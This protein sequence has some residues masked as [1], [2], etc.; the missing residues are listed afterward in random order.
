M[1]RHTQGTDF[2]PA[3]EIVVPENS[4]RYLAKHAEGF[5][6]MLTRKVILAS[7]IGASSVCLAQD[8]SSPSAEPRIIIESKIN[9]GDLPYRGLYKMYLRLLSFLPPAPHII[10][11]VTQLSFTSLPIKDEDDF[12]KSSWN[13]AIVGTDTDIDIPILRGGYF[14]FPAYGDK[15][16]K[17]ANLMFNS[18]TKTNFLRVA[19]KMRLRP[20]QALGFP[21]VKQALHEVSE[22]QKNI[23][24][25]SIGFRAEKYAKFDAIK[26]CFAE[27][28]GE[29]RLDGEVLDTIHSA[30]CRVYK[31]DPQ[32]I[33]TSRELKFSPVPEIVVLEDSARYLPRPAGS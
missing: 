15:I 20:H 9:R 2:S 32:L 23:P 6:I 17:D 22:V 14:V 19:W 26:A 1:H 28:N 27:D 16:A 12:L 7:L 13:V 25:Y 21:D 30:R 18:Q 8:H 24:W 5:Q 11:P 31:I 3:P 29:L 10:E 33:D 4:A